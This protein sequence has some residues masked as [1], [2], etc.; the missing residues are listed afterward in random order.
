LVNL[1]KNTKIGIKICKNPRDLGE[2]VKFQTTENVRIKVLYPYKII[3]SQI[4]QICTD[5]SFCAKKILLY[6]RYYFFTS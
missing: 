5:Q 3:S 6:T 2:I 4:T 1:C